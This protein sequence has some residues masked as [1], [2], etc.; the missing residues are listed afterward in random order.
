MYSDKRRIG[1]IRERTFHELFFFIFRCLKPSP[2]I[3]QD[4]RTGDESTPKV[5][6]GR[7]SVKLGM[8]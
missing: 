4:K 8:I 1:N 6:T 2:V 3:V 5:V 7:V